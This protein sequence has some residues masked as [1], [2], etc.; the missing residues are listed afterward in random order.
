MLVMMMKNKDLNL[1]CLG[2]LPL[3]AAAGRLRKRRNVSQ[4]H[5]PVAKKPEL[6]PG[7]H[8]QEGSQ[9]MKGC[10]YCTT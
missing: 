7:L 1:F 3:V 2:S 5:I 6:C 9:E 10:A 8:R 4:Q